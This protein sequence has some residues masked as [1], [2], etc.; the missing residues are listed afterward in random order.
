ME[1]TEHAFAR[2]LS[3]DAGRV[4]LGHLRQMTIERTL[5]PNASDSELRWAEAQRALVHQIE[6]LVLRGRENAKN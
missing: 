4:V 5:G 2:A 3:G 1:R 6:T